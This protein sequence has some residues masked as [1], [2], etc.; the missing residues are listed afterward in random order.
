[1][2]TV[3]VFIAWVES[4]CWLQGTE[5][6]GVGTKI[7]HVLHDELLTN[8]CIRF[9]IP[10]DPFSSYCTSVSCVWIYVMEFMKSVYGEINTNS[11]TSFV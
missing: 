1:M 4:S 3:H 9:L 2:C 5:Y 7:E 10:K 8:T 11:N 6:L